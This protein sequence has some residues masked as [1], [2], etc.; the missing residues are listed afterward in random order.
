MNSLDL[1]L[2][3][4]QFWS[5]LPW[6]YQVRNKSM[7]QLTEKEAERTE[8]YVNSRALRMSL[9]FRQYLNNRS[10]HRCRPASAL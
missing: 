7:R 9:H 1:Q 5:L 6:I 10:L 4:T 2:S 8:G 3:A